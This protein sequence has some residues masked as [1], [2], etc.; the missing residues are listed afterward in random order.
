MPAC[1]LKG[2]RSRQTMLGMMKKPNTK[3]NFFGEKIKSIPSLKQYKCLKKIK[4]GSTSTHHIHTIA[5]Y[6]ED[7][8]IDEPWIKDLFDEKPARSLESIHNAI[9]PSKQ[10]LAAL[11]AYTEKI[12]QLERKRIAHDLH[13]DLGGHLSAVKMMLSHVWKNLPQT[14]ALTNHY[15]YL[16]QLINACIDSIHTISADV[17]PDVIQAGLPSALAYLANELER[18]AQ[19]PCEFLC[20]LHTADIDKKVAATLF[21]IAQEAC[22]NVRKHA[23]ATSAELHL[24]SKRVKYNL[25]LLTMVVVSL[26]T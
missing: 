20:R 12:R 4:Y 2:S 11:E 14:A 25:N 8:M 9:P 17:I 18:Q 16:D 13:D 24:Y 7:A 3:P 19:I 15:A 23:N 6:K 22:T 5:I 26:K 21:R 1:W 10:Q